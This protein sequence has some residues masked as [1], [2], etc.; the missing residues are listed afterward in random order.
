MFFFQLK[1]LGG[2]GWGKCGG[3][4]KG[5]GEGYCHQD[6]LFEKNNLFSIKRNYEN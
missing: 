2:L 1:N 5:K 3:T 4:R 6:I